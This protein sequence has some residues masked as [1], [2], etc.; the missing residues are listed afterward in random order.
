MMLNNADNFQSPGGGV[1]GLRET[2]KKDF[3]QYIEPKDTF[4]LK[5]AL[6]KA[7]LKN[8]KGKRSTD[9]INYHHKHRQAIV[10]ELTQSTQSQDIEYEV[11]VDYIEPQ[12]QKARKF[13]SGQGSTGGMEKIDEKVPTDWKEILDEWKGLEQ[14]RKIKG[15]LQCESKEWEVEWIDADEKFGKDL[16]DADFKYPEHRLP[17]E[18]L[19]GSA[20][21]GWQCSTGGTRIK[22]SKNRAKI[23][24]TRSMY[25]KKTLRGD[26]PTGITETSSA[27]KVRQNTD[28]LSASITY[29]TDSESKCEGLVKKMLNTPMKVML[30][31]KGTRLR[32]PMTNNEYAEATVTLVT[33]KHEGSVSMLTV[34]LKIGDEKYGHLAELRLHSDSSTCTVTDPK[35]QQRL[36]SL[37][38]LK[39]LQLNEN[40]TFGANK[41]GN[42]LD[43]INTVGLSCTKVKRTERTWETCKSYYVNCHGAVDYKY[44]S[45]SFSE[46]TCGYMWD[47]NSQRGFTGP[48]V[49]EFAQWCTERTEKGK[50]DHQEKL[51]FLKQ[52]NTNCDEFERLCEKKATDLEQKVCTPPLS[53]MGAVCRSVLA[54][55][56]TATTPHICAQYA[57]LCSVRMCELLNPDKKSTSKS[58]STK[59]LEISQKGNDKKEDDAEEQDEEEE[60]EITTLGISIGWK[61]TMTYNPFAPQ[62]NRIK[63]SSP[64]LPYTALTCSAT[65]DN[66][67]TNAVA[68]TSNDPAESSDGLLS[69]LAMPLFMKYV[70]QGEF[71]IDFCMGQQTRCDEGGLENLLRSIPGFI[72]GEPI[73][74]KI[75]A[76]IPKLKLGGIAFLMAKEFSNGD[77]KDAEALLNSMGDVAQVG[78]V[79][80]SV[81]LRM[82]GGTI[83][84]EIRG[85]PDVTD[86]I[87]CDSET[88]NILS[89]KIADSI[90][91]GV[92]NL[93]VVQTVLIQ[94]TEIEL[95]TRLASK[96][97]VI[98]DESYEWPI[99]LE[100]T[101][102]LGPS[103]FAR[104]VIATPS[105]MSLGVSLGVKLSPPKQ[106]YPIIF[107]GEL[108]VK[109]G[110]VG[111]DVE[112]ELTMIGSWYNVFDIKFLHMN[113]A[114]VGLSIAM[115]YPPVP[116]AFKLGGGLC[117]GLEAACLSS[118]G[119]TITGRFY[120]GVDIKEPN[121]N[122]F[123][124]MFTDVTMRKVLG[125]LG[126]VFGQS[127]HQAKD[128]L[129]AN[130]LDSGILPIKKGCTP[131]QIQDVGNYPDCYARMSYSPGKVSI[132]FVSVIISVSVLTF[133]FFF[134]FVFIVC[135]FY[136]HLLHRN[137]ILLILTKL[138]RPTFDLRSPCRQGSNY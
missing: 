20:N 127:F 80:A 74:G 115:T 51:D 113:D 81:T 53:D 17:V 26:S 96:P 131:A 105:S 32:D 46:N 23:P 36:Q 118:S 102:K 68:T 111:V 122:Y 1:C 101:Q 66:S 7:W 59:L 42:C 45:G 33:I 107:A 27:C 19:D 16:P 134:F 86:A 124:G 85:S 44:F 22:N 72:V 92:S 79:D 10:T 43:A 14:I 82:I 109:S 125:I 37:K 48:N 112:G 58:A 21:G 84:I 40:S 62:N 93:V 30:D 120:A 64:V 12:L 11:F 98:Q 76:T 130:I 63:P 78:L 106:P 114:E 69:D 38:T 9:N 89:C 90:A 6:V 136:R 117:I 133:H 56:E 52:Y 55:D 29:G 128:K 110:V 25:P 108:A 95:E 100:D 116:S 61:Y 135:L 2:V 138:T 83:S 13:W 24:Q 50:V 103:F 75:T 123:A 31:A 126:D 5:Q 132:Y 91:N 54:R 121:D 70:Q 137:W 88:G 77:E 4:E 94:A 67:N 28:V 15:T 97:I 60:E 35:P 3:P 8:D 18:E 41:E 73:G 71:R 39:S 129:P 99:S 47:A 57:E 104:F 119:N 34:E 65:T 87:T 49:V